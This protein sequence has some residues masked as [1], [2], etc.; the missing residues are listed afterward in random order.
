MALSSVKM[1][2]SINH[3]PSRRL[4]MGAVEEGQRLEFRLVDLHRVGSFKYL[5]SEVETFSP[6]DLKSSI[7]NTM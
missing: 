1:Q 6:S 7:L 4:H 2:A 5:E 3:P